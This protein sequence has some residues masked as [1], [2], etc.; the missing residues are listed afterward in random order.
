MERRGSSGAASEI[1]ESGGS[2]ASV[3]AEGHRGHEPKDVASRCGGR[4]PGRGFCSWEEA[5]SSLRAG[6]QVGRTG[7]GVGKW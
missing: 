6:G 7:V 4:D 2:A 5:T 1:Q 3:Q